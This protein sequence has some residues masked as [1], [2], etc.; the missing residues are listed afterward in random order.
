MSN[1]P[2]SILT[3]QAVELLQQLIAIPSFSKEEDRTAYL[4]ERFLQERG[5]TTHR[6]L[7]NVWA[8]NQHFDPAKPSLL[9]H[10]TRYTRIFLPQF[11]LRSFM[12][13]KSWSSNFMYKSIPSSISA[14]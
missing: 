10:C 13:Y 4:L 11:H 7:N 14:R 9:L 5:V 12:F 3:Q 2:S 6:H 8:K 1:Q